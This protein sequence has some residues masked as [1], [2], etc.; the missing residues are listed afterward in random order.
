MKLCHVYTK[1]EYNK[2]FL[3]FSIWLDELQL[4]SAVNIK[5]PKQG[6]GFQVYK[7]VKEMERDD[8]KH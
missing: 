4:M 7:A 5:A 3:G 6:A 8:V 2:N 1:P